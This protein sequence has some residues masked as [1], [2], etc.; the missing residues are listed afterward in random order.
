MADS[1][2][3]FASG[4]LVGAGSLTLKHKLAAKLA[5]RRA[6]KA[7]AVA[8]ERALERAEAAEALLKSRGYKVVTRD[9]PASRLKCSRISARTSMLSIS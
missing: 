4:L 6:K 2:V 1:L 3:A 5:A 9:A 7:A 8:R